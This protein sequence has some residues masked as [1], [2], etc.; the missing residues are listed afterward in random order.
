MKRLLA[1]VLVVLA[2]ATAALGATTPKPAHFLL[3]PAQVGT[4]YILVL[5]DG[6]QTLKRPTLDICHETLPSEKLR[7]ARDLVG[8]VRSQ[9][10]AAISNEI[11]V[12]K[13]GGAAQALR[14]VVNGVK[15]C[16]N[17]PVVVGTTSITTRIA[18]LHPKGRFLPGW[19]AFGY[20]Q[21]GTIAGHAVS[22]YAALLYQRRGNVLS[23]VVAHGS[24]LPERLKALTRAGG[25]SAA[26]LR[27]G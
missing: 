27:K 20:H 3:K 25:A 24:S 18:T 21:T 10:D 6:G 12:Y 15:R 4:G 5:V 22:Q 2:T 16:P 14:D 8:F 7:L 9:T 19:V 23:V 17:G 11:V 13:P 1:A 26:N